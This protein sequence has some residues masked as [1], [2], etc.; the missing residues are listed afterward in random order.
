MT[1][2]L[3]IRAPLRDRPR[4]RPG[5]RFPD[6]RYVPGLHPHPVRD[7]G[8]HSYGNDI[9]AGE[10]AS[11]RGADWRESAE[12]L[13]GVDL[14]NHFYFWEAHEAWESLWRDAEAGSDAKLFLQ[15]L[16]QVSAALLKT[17][18]GSVDGASRL[19]TTGIEKLSSVSERNPKFMGLNVIETVMNMRT[20]FSPLAEGVLP[21]IDDG[22]PPLRLCADGPAEEI[23]R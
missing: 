9:V 14:F 3:E 16:I 19:S 12:W 10:H 21:A 4:Y 5:Q 11:G 13:W 6:Y 7:P 18:L 8:G 1:A 20:Y 15:G 17:H 23:R 22:V 2:K